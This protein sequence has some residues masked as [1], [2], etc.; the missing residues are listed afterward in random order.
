M[1]SKVLR[2]VA[3]VTAFLLFAQETR[4]FSLQQQRP[5][6]KLTGPI[7]P[8]MIFSPSTSPQS[9]SPLVLYSD[10][11]NYQEE[12]EQMPPS[13]PNPPPLVPPKR[14]DPLMASLTRMD[15]SSV[16]V[17]TKNIPFLGEIPVDGSLALLIPAAGIAAVGFILSIVIA[18]RSSDEIVG[19]LSQVSDGINQAAVSKSSQVYDED[20]CRGICSSQ[21]QDLDGLRSF[22]EGLKK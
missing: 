12:A 8:L 20:L 21:Q 1:A 22:M 10:N 2:M 17:P 3:V 13:T 9:A 4:S 7:Q 6:S 19:L 15:P 11:G 14:L 18:V 16:D 5:T